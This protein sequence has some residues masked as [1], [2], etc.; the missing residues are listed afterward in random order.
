MFFWFNPLQMHRR[1]LPLGEVQLAWALRL[2]RSPGASGLHAMA[3]LRSTS[4]EG[5]C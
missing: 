1:L 3:S 4:A 2:L 5:P